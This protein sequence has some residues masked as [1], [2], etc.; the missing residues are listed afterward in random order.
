MH[1]VASPATALWYII[2]YNG[3]SREIAAEMSFFN[4]ETIVGVLIGERDKLVDY[5]WSE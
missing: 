2:D 3:I 5:R 1:I 4:P